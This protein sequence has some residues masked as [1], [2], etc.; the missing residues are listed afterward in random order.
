MLFPNGGIYHA[1]KKN[2]PGKNVESCLTFLGHQSKVNTI[3]NVVTVVTMTP[4]GRL[5]RRI[6][7]VIIVTVVTTVKCSCG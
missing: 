3:T 4:M 5:K 6:T 7:I 1:E 2:D